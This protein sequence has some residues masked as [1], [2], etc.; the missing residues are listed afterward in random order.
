MDPPVTE[1]SADPAEPTAPEAPPPQV[2][3]ALDS[4]PKGAW[5][6]L[7]GEKMGRA[8]IEL[9]L[10][11]GAEATV[12]FSLPGYRTARRRVV[13]SHDQTLLV[14]LEPKARPEPPP[15]KTEF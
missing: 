8:P 10:D 11:R 2:T 5:V 6:A 7:N 3:I 14:R 1:K 12:R 15:I 9:A 4:R 13:A